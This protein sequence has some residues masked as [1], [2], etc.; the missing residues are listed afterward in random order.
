MKSK[1][2]QHVEL[3]KRMRRESEEKLEKELKRSEEMLE[4]LR[5]NTATLVNLSLFNN[6]R[7][8]IFNIILHFIEYG[9]S[10]TSAYAKAEFVGDGAA[11]KCTLH[12]AAR[13]DGEYVVLNGPCGNSK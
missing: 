10:G 5:D 9:A 12:G 3:Q 8:L 4:E 2:L 13:S 11:A 6:L 7:W 1:A